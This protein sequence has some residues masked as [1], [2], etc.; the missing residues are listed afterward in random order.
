MLLRVMPPLPSAVN[1]RF[2]SASLSQSTT[3]RRLRQWQQVVGKGQGT[4]LNSS[5]PEVHAVPACS[6]NHPKE[7]AEKELVTAY[8]AWGLISTVPPIGGPS[9]RNLSMPT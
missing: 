3:T 1:V 4:H 9:A 7:V 5:S 2:L 8:P 6:S